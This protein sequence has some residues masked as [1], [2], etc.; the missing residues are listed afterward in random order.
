[1][2]LR[3]VADGNDTDIRE[4]HQYGTLQILPQ[5]HAQN[6]FSLSLSLSSKESLIIIQWMMDNGISASWVFIQ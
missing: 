3:T 6:L 4:L 1:M 5:H 2:V